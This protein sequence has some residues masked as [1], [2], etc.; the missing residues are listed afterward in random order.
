MLV[1]TANW[2]IAD[3]TIRGGPTQSVVQHFLQEVRRA[4]WRFGFRQSGHYKPIQSIKILLAGDTL[5]GLTTLAW[6]DRSRP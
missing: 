1:I 6:G 5:D 3:G 4:A 2:A